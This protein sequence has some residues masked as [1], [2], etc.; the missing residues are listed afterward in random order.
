MLDWQA[1]VN[2]QL[3]MYEQL[4]WEFFSAF[5]IDEK[6]SCNNEPCYIRFKLGDITHEINLARFSESI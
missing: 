4:V 3:P 6:G 1:F 5:V 2:L